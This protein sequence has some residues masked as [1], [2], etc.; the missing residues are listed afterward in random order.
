MRRFH[1][2]EIA[3]TDA[4]VKRKNNVGRLAISFMNRWNLSA[5]TGMPLRKEGFYCSFK[6][7]NLLSIR[8]V[9]ANN[10]LFNNLYINQARRIL[11]NCLVNDKKII[12]WRENYYQKMNESHARKK[13][14]WHAIR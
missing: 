1:Q 10:F 13:A 11:K 3:Y 2:K 6:E 9:Q 5:W 7:R 8:P 4:L 14:F 12:I